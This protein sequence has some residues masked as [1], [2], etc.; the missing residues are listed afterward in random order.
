MKT[1]SALVASLL[2]LSGC[3][4]AGSSSSTE[5]SVSRTV[6]QSCEVEGV[7]AAFDEQ[8]EGSAY[9]PTEWQPS[10]G[11]DLAAALDAGG[12]VC[13]YG[14]QVAEVG[15]T[16]MW[17]PADDELW[18]NRSTEWQGYGHIPVDLEG[19]EEDEAFILQEGTSAD[20]MHVWMINFLIDGI[21][22]QIGATFL[23]TVEEASGLIAAAI[24]ATE[25]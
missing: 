11:T 14:I 5:E 4:S 17:V 9:V 6:P 8:V 16:V 21:W 1:L 25:S 23:Q 12:I 7:I 22:I 13:S 18:A 24:A 10:E 15:G 19:V 3:S 20:E 2:L